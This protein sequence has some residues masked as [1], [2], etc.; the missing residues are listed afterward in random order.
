MHTFIYRHIS[1]GSFTWMAFWKR[2]QN[3]LKTLQASS[4]LNVLSSSQK[5]SA[6]AW[7]DIL[8]LST[9]SS[10]SLKRSSATWH[11]NTGRVD[12]YIYWN[13]MHLWFYTFIFS[14]K[15]TFNIVNHKRTFAVTYHRFYTSRKGC[16]CCW[17]SASVWMFAFRVTTLLFILSMSSSTDS[18]DNLRRLEIELAAVFW[19]HWCY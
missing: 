18:S 6:R 17:I 4:S 14:L 16:V 13:T 3:T 2:W 15:Q 10:A 11:R 5:N 1:F 8:I 7:L 19:T 9:S 12:G